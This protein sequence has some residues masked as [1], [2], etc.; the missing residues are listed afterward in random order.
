MTYKCFYLL[1]DDFSGKFQNPFSPKLFT[2][3]FGDLIKN[4]PNI[5]SPKIFSPN[6]FAVNVIHLSLSSTALFPCLVGCLSFSL[7]CP[8]LCLLPMPTSFCLCLLPLYIYRKVHTARAIYLVSV[9]IAVICMYVCRGS[10]RNFFGAVAAA[11]KNFSPRGC[12]AGRF[13]FYAWLKLTLTKKNSLRNVIN[14]S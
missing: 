3:I 2:E 12:T 5:C 13:L 4:P 7:T 10:S 1:N 9:L 8:F 6:I 14:K 11:Q